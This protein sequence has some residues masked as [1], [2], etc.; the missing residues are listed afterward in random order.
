[1]QNVKVRFNDPSE[2]FEE[3]TRDL[4]TLVDGVVRITQRFVSQAGFPIRKVHVIA[5]FLRAAEGVV[6]VVELDAVCGDYWPVAASV[7]DDATAI[8]RA[9]KIIADLRTK[10]EA[11]NYRALTVAAGHFE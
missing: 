2:F 3:L 6:Q 9:E 4:S 7:A 11:L 5:G 1:M 10:I 8:T